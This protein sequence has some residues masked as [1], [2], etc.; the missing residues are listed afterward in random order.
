[1]RNLP[2]KRIRVVGVVVSH[3]R[4]SNS[5]L[6]VRIG[7]AGRREKYRRLVLSRCRLALSKL[8]RECQIEGCLSQESLQAAMCSNRFGPGSDVENPRSKK[9]PA[10]EGG[11]SNVSEKRTAPLAWPKMGKGPVRRASYLTSNAGDVWQDAG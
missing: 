5:L 1:M 2:R 9:A 6:G 7:V 10:F 3:C 8:L 4:Q 11:S